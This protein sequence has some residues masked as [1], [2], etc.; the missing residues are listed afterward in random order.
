[1]QRRDPRPE[2]QGSGRDGEPAK[3][4]ENKASRADVLGVVCFQDEVIFVSCCSWIK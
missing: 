2:L 3:E 4:N 1:M